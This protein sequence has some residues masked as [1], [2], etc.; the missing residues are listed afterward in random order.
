ML[1]LYVD[2][3]SRERLP[4]GGQAVAIGFGRMNPSQLEDRLTTGSC[5]LLYDEEIRCQGILR[6]G[7]WLDGWV[8]DIIAGT[9][10]DLLAGEFD[11]LRAATK[12]AAIGVVE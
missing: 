9:I 10:E 5:V 3:N 8:A 1:A 11:R 12:R 2:F 4:G 7:I 6:R